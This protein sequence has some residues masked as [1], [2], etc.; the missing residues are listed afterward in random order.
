MYNLRVEEL[1]PRCLWNGNAFSHAAPA[2]ASAAGTC[3]ARAAEHS[4][5]VDVGDHASSAGTAG[6]RA[7]RQAAPAPGAAPSAAG[8]AG[9]PESQAPAGPR[10]AM[11]AVQ[12][13]GSA[14]AGAEAPVAGPEVAAG[15]ETTRTGP[16]TPPPAQGEAAGDNRGPAAPAETTSASPP[17]R[18]ARAPAPRV[19]VMVAT[20]GPRIEALGLSVAR[21]PLEAVRPGEGGV[22]VPWPVPRPAAPSA[23]GG[24]ALPTPAAPGAGEAAE[25]PAV[26]AGQPGGLLTVLPP[27]DLSALERGVQEFL[28]QLE[29][30][31]RHLAEPGEET[32]VWPWVVA[33][34]AAVA[35]C[36]LARRQWRRPDEPTAGQNPLPGPPRALSPRS[37][38]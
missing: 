35:A 4:A 10:A 11:P 25:G 12:G 16:E 18:L 30:L 24:S 23:G 38:S 8:S 15:S 9:P 32:G 22:L 33:A 2:S 27:G 19:D 20:A 17:E 31:G 28:R 13:G 7:S 34:A 3:P 5:F 21:S 14:G 36:E 37:R 26:P 6:P 1:E 29:Q